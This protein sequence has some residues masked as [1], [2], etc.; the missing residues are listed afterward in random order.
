MRIGNCLFVSIAIL[1]NLAAQNAFINMAEIES[2]MAFNSMPYECRFET[3]CEYGVGFV[4]RHID[5]NVKATDYLIIETIAK[6]KARNGDRVEILPEVQQNEKLLR[7]ALLKNVKENKNPDLRINGHFVEIKEPILPYGK[8]TIGNSINLAADQ[9]DKVII[10]IRDNNISE[11][12][13]YRIANGKLKQIK[14]LQAIEFRHRDKYLAFI[15]R[16]GGQ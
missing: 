8:N 16:S 1:C 9:A 13:L 10:N 3:I 4:R 12:Q 5:V 7:D 11:F 15:K 2:L 6:E 14:S